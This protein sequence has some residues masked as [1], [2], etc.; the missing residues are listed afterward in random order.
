MERHFGLTANP[1]KGDD[2]QLMGADRAAEID[3]NRS[4]TVVFLIWNKINQ[5][6]IR[7]PVDDQ[8][9]GSFLAIM[10]RKKQHCSPKIGVTQRRMR[11]QK[12]PGQ[13]RNITA[14]RSHIE[15]LGSDHL[16]FKRR[17]SICPEVLSNV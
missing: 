11:N 7:W 14:K 1:L 2:R 12:L 13:I 8:S 4:E 15:N 16:L 6:L 10:G 3:R 5:T 17:V 9:M